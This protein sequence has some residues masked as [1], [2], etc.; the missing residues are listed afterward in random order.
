MRL[1]HFP[2]ALYVRLFGAAGIGYVVGG[3]GVAPTDMAL[4]VAGLSCT[5]SLAGWLMMRPIMRAAKKAISTAHQNN[6]S[7]RG[8]K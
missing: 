3:A 7:G 4:A 1:Q 5:A 2:V 8:K 6:A